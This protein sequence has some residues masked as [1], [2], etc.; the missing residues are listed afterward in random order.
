MFGKPQWFRP[1]TAGF[2]LVPVSWP[3]WL[4]TGGWISAIAVPFLLLIWRHQPLEATAW[5][6]LAMGALYFD[7]RSIR[8]AILG[9]STSN[10]AKAAG[11]PPKTDDNVLYILDSQPGQQAA[12]RNYNLQ[13]RR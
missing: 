7:V 3:G 1:K 12:T 9:P 8:R 13:V 2:G 11:S 10:L 5:M 4:Y 6:A